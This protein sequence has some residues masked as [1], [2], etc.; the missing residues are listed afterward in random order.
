MKKPIGKAKR[1][2]IDTD[3]KSWVKVSHYSSTQPSPLL[4]QPAFA[5]VDIVAW[6]E[7]NSET[8]EE[9]LLENRALLF[10]GFDV[11]DYAIFEKFIMAT[12]D[13]NLLEY[14]D[15]T[16][17]R[18]KKSSG[19]Y[20]STIHPSDQT[21]E[22]HN[23]GTYWK[24][25]PLKLYFYS[26]ITPNS[27]GET[28]I[29]DTRKVYQRIPEDIRQTFAEK[30]IALV[31]NFNDG[32]GLT[33]QE[34]FQSTDKNEVES[35]CQENDIQCLW[36]DD[37]RLRTIQV[38][39]AI[40]HHPQTGEPIWFNHTAF[41]HWSSL[42]EPM[43]SLLIEEYGIDGLPYN[44]TYGDG[45]A[46]EESVVA[47]IR[48]AYQAERFQFPWQSGDIM[49]LDNMSMAHSRNPFEGERQVLV[50]MTNAYPEPTL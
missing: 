35:Y 26:K 32:F 49:L 47:T 24:R 27:G 48:Q 34:V 20:S 13:K 38:R 21:I 45:D 1:K 7:K 43:K 9:L 6:A 22:L 14:K 25:W 23:E 50:A 46:I 39:E 29:A 28:P 37:G 10:R 4:I 16:T 5:N 3:T 11:P 15:R 33:W 17:P 31:R 2:A 12:S 41:F 19:I 36:K 42:K 40:Q 18:D 30:K 8:I 44:V